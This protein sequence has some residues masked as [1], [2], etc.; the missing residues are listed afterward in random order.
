MDVRMAQTPP[1]MHVAGAQPGDV[2]W[3]GPP[4]GV[5]PMSPRS[6]TRGP[7]FEGRG[8]P[9]GGPGGGGGYCSRLLLLPKLAQMR[10]LLGA[11]PTVR[12]R[13]VRRRRIGPI[14]AASSPSIVSSSGAGAVPFKMG[15]GTV[16]LHGPPGVRLDMST[17]AAAVLARSCRHCGWAH[18]RSLH[19]I[20]G[21][22]LSDAHAHRI[23]TTRSMCGQ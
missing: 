10:L 13:R 21:G 5:V 19:H 14:S 23:G 7:P 18:S 8:D 11:P 2:D 15:Q 6:A 1:M 17:D 3:Q 4:Q 12:R 22:N 16:S 20:A 9:G